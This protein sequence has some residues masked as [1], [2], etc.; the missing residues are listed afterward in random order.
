MMTRDW[1]F[2]RQ[3]IT[4][5][6]IATM[7]FMAAAQGIRISPFSGK[8][9]A[10]HFL[11]HTLGFAFFMICGA[12]PFGTGYKGAWLF[13]LAPAGAFRGVARG[14]YARLLA[15]VLGPH[16]M[17]LPLLAWYWGIPDAILF[18]AYSAVASSVYLALEL[19][20]IEGMPFTRQPQIAG[21]PYILL[22][23]MAGGLL[24]A[25]AVALQY[26]LIFRSPTVVIAVT[27]ALTVASWMLA[28]SSLDT[29][30]IAIRFH[31]GMV[32]N[33]SKGIYTEVN[34]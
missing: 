33:E 20:L 3:M 14:V 7:L 2:R 22:I 32:S 26:L 5:I 13:L 21:N 10:V 19:R 23:L 8:F 11:P 28:R 1:Q 29:M 6:P 17:L 34:G 15:L 9:T 25:I 30:E 24:M 12:I 18:L 4:L 16:L 27:A 31:L